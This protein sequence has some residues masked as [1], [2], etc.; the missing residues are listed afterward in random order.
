MMHANGR[1]QLLR[2][3]AWAGDLRG[4]HREH[5][6]VAASHELK[7]KA[8]MSKPGDVAVVIVQEVCLHA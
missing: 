2:E 1:S 6:I 5:L 3:L 8:A 4:E 7:H